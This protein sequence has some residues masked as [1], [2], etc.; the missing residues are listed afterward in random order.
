MDLTD[1]D[2]RIVVRSQAATFSFDKR[3]GIICSWKVKGRDVVD[4][5]YG[6]CPNYWRDPVDNDYGSQEPLRSAAYFTV[7]APDAV[8]ARKEDGKVVIEVSGKGVRAS[9]TYTVYPDG[10]LRIDVRT[11]GVPGPKGRDTRVFI[12]R[13]GF[14]FFVAGDAF[15]YFGRGPVENYWD[16][17]TGSFKHIWKGSARE[18]YYPYVRPQESGHHTDAEW[19]EVDGLSVT[20]EGP[21]EFNVT[22]RG[23]VDAYQV[24][25]TEKPQTHLCDVQDFDATQVCID[26]RMT[27]IGG[28]DS[29]KNRP[30][31]ERCLWEDQGYAYSFIL[32]PGMKGEKANK[33][34]L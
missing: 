29:W 17:A 26:Y 27:G 13:L 28:L 3:K 16:R 2:T 8:S 7:P 21:F 12:P 4:P 19:L 20:S 15:R 25:R 5:R 10:S 32:R 33:Y 1:G 22:S 11:Q 30:E 24:L 31:P 23:M 34:T 6:L 14:R 9:E 18:E